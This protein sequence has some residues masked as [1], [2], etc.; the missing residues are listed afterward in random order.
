MPDQHNGVIFNANI[1][2][3]GSTNFILMHIPLIFKIDRL[4]TNEPIHLNMDLFF[5]RS[6]Y[7]S[8]LDQ[9]VLIGFARE[10]TWEC[11]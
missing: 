2:F 10:I 3:S 5:G 1:T 4:D 8:H 9:Y 6:D 7:Q 11:T